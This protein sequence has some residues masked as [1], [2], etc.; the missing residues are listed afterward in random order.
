MKKILAYVIL[1]TFAL[2]LVTVMVSQMGLIG[3]GLIGGGVSAG[4]LLI[5]A[6]DQI[7]G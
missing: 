3:M 1:G 7:W 2:T 4:L 6:F 5:W